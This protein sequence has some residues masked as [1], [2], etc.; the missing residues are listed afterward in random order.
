MVT[1]Q[2]K[3]LTVRIAEAGAELQS[4]QTAD[5]TEFLWQGDPAFWSKRAPVLF[6]ICGALKNNEYRYNGVG[7]TLQKHGYARLETFEV[8]RVTTDEAVFL[9]RSDENSRVQYPF[10]YELRIGYRLVGKTVEIV[11]DVRNLSAAPL[12]MSIGAHEAYACPEGIEQYEVV[13][14]NPETL[15]TTPD[16]LNSNDT[17]LVIENSRVLPL[18]EEDYA[19]D[20]LIFRDGTQSDSLTLRHKET[21][22]GVEIRYEGFEHLLFWQPYKAP[23]ICV[24]P[25]CGYPDTPEC[26]GDIT[27][28]VGIQ[29]VEG[30]DAFHRVHS[31]TVL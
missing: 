30:G 11:Y 15:Y 7:Y 1:L 16:P 13:F 26:D 21:G 2:N 18:R 17:Q 19:I 4:I 6:P 14:S 12:Y 5:G 25:W 9:L 31:I 28:K 27:K 22:R 3:E 23:F 29:K 20:A 10:E 24:E 8:E